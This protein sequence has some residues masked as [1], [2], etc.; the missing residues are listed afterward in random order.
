MGLLDWIIGWFF[1]TLESSIHHRENTN[2]KE[3]LYPF[4]GPEHQDP[5][6]EGVPEVLCLWARASRVENPYKDLVRQ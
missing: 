3:G 2:M 5:Y 1:F 6:V 4:H